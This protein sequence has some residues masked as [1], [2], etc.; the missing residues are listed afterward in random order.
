MIHVVKARQRRT[1]S[2]MGASVAKER[3][4]EA[5]VNE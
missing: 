5:A 4:P 1:T 3:P 2:E